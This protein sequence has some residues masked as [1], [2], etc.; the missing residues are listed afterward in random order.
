MTSPELANH[1][2]ANDMMWVRYDLIDV[3]FY[4]VGEGGT[5]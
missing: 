1:R 4:P 3:D 2:M 5:R